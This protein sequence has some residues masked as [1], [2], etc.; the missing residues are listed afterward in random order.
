MFHIF[1]TSYIH[2]LLQPICCKNIFCTYIIYSKLGSISKTMF[3][4]IF[5]LGQSTTR[6][7]AFLFSALYNDSVDLAVDRLCTQIHLYLCT[8][9]ANVRI[10]EIYNY[11]Q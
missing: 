5:W 10:P 2:V 7:T 6:S 8:W 1:N 4:L 9:V 3:S 11:E